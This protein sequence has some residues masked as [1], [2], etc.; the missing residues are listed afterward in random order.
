MQNAAKCNTSKSFK[1]A[2]S[3]LWLFRLPNYPRYHATAAFISAAVLYAA[4]KLRRLALCAFIQLGLAGLSSY[5]KP[6][7]LFWHIYP[8]YNLRYFTWAPSFV[9][10]FKYVMSFMRR[11][12]IYTFTAQHLTYIQGR[13]I[14][15]K[16][17]IETRA[18]NSGLNR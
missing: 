1:R 4:T 16:V 9:Q 13:N 12:K 8:Y 3:H 6:I 18:M 15:K 17:S 2:V 7:N 10:F 14:L 5:F 11:W